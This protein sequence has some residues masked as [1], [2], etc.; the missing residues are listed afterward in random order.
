[1]DE[2]VADGTRSNFEMIFFFTGMTFVAAAFIGLFL[3][4]APDE[5]HT[6]RRGG[7]DLLLAAYETFKTD[8]NFRR[9]AIIAALFG[10]YLTLFPHYQRLGRD[11]LDLG[12]SALIP[13]LLAQNIGAALFSIPTGWIADRFGNRL[14]IQLILLVLCIAPA[15]ALFLSWSDDVRPAWFI[16]VFGLLGL[17]P[18]AM[19]FLNNYTLEIASH[20]EHPHY[21]ST[22]AF[23]IAAPPIL[24]S[25]L[26]GA[27]IDWVGFELIFAIV[28]G[29]V[30]S[31][32]LM[33]FTLVE[34][35]KLS[36][37]A[38]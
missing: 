25:P 12:L 17:T 33:A 16:V 15:L 34:P 20:G 28:I 19:R 37:G 1:V 24:L 21:L 36:S 29:C 7:K 23:A 5:N 13:W 9:L 11:R 26:I 22:L 4:E 35:R 3:K 6:Q 30:F 8:R 10:M 38:K 27:L 14:V 31:G 18:V 2:S 32:W